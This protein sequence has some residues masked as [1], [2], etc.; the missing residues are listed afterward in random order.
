[1]RATLPDGTPVGSSR[2]TASRGRAR[3]GG[4]RALGRGRRGPLLARDGWTLLLERCEPGEPLCGSTASRAGGAIDLLPRL[5]VPAGPPFRRSRTRRRGGAR[6]CPITG[7]AGR[8]FE[9]RLLDA[10]L[11]ALDVCRRTQGEQVLVHQDLHGDNVLSAQ[12]EPWLV[13]DP[14][15][16]LA[17]RSS[18]SRRSSAPPN[19]ATAAS[20]SSP[21][22]P[23]HRRVGLDRER[24]RLWTL[25]ATIAWALD[26]PPSHVEVA[27][28]L[29]RAR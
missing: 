4:A 18:R 29:R 27:R 9:R 15:P 13:I 1:M 22:R 16:L 23:P 3:G 6:T 10:A 20:R 24:A 14:K 2:S 28:W 8:P 21:A 11:D 25:G 12:R 17:E 19:S 7:S 5:W 26:G